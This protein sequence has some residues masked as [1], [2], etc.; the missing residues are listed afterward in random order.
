MS[1][2]RLNGP[3]YLNCS[4]SR[5][6]SA[7]YESDTSNVFVY[8]PFTFLSFHIIFLLP[9]SYSANPFSRVNGSSA[10][11]GLAETLGAEPQ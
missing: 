1:K 6:T 9:T 5:T 11:G 3:S 8:Y 7:S 4:S 2:S 10:G